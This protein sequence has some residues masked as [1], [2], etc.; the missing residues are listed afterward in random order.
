[1]SA[2]GVDSR[3]I[4]TTPKTATSFARHA[5]TLA[6]RT[7]NDSDNAMPSSKDSYGH[8]I[9]NTP[10]EKST[11]DDAQDGTLP[12]SGSGGNSIK[13]TGQSGIQTSSSR[14]E[15]KQIR[16]G[17][18]EILR[19]K[20]I[21]DVIQTVEENE[22]MAPAMDNFSGIPGYEEVGHVPTLEEFRLEWPK[23]GSRSGMGSPQ[24]NGAEVSKGRRKF[25]VQAGQTQQGSGSVVN[26]LSK[27]DEVFRHFKKYYDKADHS[28][29]RRGDP[30]FSAGV[31]ST[32]LLQPDLDVIEAVGRHTAEAQESR[33]H[34]RIGEGVISTPDG[35]R[36]QRSVDSNQSQPSKM[37]SKGLN[38][39]GDDSIEEWS[40]GDG[41]TNVFRE[42]MQGSKGA[43]ERA[44]QGA[45]NAFTIRSSRSDDDPERTDTIGSNSGSDGRSWPKGKKPAGKKPGPD[46]QRVKGPLEGG[47]TSV[48]LQAS[49][50]SSSLSVHT[51]TEESK[52]HTSLYGV[53]RSGCSYE[54]RTKCSLSCKLR[55]LGGSV[56]ILTTYFIMI[57]VC[58]C[59]GI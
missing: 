54:P 37:S 26:D 56:G 4:G 50:Y 25:Q 30:L 39:L 53:H 47:S 20:G 6:P 23:M 3:T 15:S 35:A 24:E 48:E 12:R 29:G 43:I 55:L 17:Q 9:A 42:S 5:T 46:S 32:G 2:E 59:P 22:L 44:A 33:S 28:G 41:F 13:R 1:M 21:K 10:K 8:D 19:G 45:R 36:V 57:A 38:G 58:L 16:S 40:K 34:S 18:E 27:R 31:R 7:T 52:R 14:R 11:G 49:I 51:K